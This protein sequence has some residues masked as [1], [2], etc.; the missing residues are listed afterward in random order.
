MTH[1]YS[2]WVPALP[3]S[4]QTQSA[5]PL[6]RPTMGSRTSPIPRCPLFPHGPI[7]GH[8]YTGPCS[9]QQGRHLH[10]YYPLGAYG[11]Y[12]RSISS[13]LILT[14]RLLPSETRRRLGR[15]DTTLSTGIYSPYGTGGGE[16]R[17]YRRPGR[18][19]IVWQSDFVLF[20]RN[21][22]FFFTFPLIPPSSPSSDLVDETPGWCNHGRWGQ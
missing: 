9:A 14:V 12:V 8:P 20:G 2:W 3:C 22:Y 4:M 19:T 6:V 5:G 17:P 21:V 13:L 18:R 10:I 1:T 11:T 15:Q 16:L 7:N